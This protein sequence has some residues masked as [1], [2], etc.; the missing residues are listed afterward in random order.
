MKW[1]FHNRGYFSECGRYEIRPT[2]ID[3]HFSYRARVTAT[4]ELVVSSADLTFV[5][6]C[7]ERHVG[8]LSTEAA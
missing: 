2:Y 5:Q 7:C 8:K 4:D 1:L 3:G 6:Q